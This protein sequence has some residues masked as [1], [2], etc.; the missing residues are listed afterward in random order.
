MKASNVMGIAC[1]MVFAPH[2]SACME[3]NALQSLTYEQHMAQFSRSLDEL[4]QEVTDLSK[5]HIGNRDSGRTE[6]ISARCPVNLEKIDQMRMHV[7]HVCASLKSD[8]LHTQNIAKTDVLQ[9]VRAIFNHL[10]TRLGDTRKL[11]ETYNTSHQRGKLLH[12]ALDPLVEIQEHLN[13]LFGI[14]DGYP[15]ASPH[16]TTI[17]QVLLTEARSFSLAKAFMVA[18]SFA[19]PSPTMGRQSPVSGAQSDELSEESIAMGVMNNNQR[20]STFS[21]SHNIR[22][23][24][25]KY[26]KL[27]RNRAQTA[28]KLAQKNPEH[29]SSV[30]ADL[31]HRLCGTEFVDETKENLGLIE[32]LCMDYPEDSQTLKE[33]KK[34]GDLTGK[35]LAKLLKATLP[36]AVVS[37]GDL[38]ECVEAVVTAAAKQSDHSAMGYVKHQAS[39]AA[40]NLAK[41]TGIVKE[42]QINSITKH[43]NEGNPF[44]KRVQKVTRIIDQYHLKGMLNTMIAALEGFDPFVTMMIGRAADFYIE[45]GQDYGKVLNIVRDLKGYNIT[46]TQEQNKVLLAYL[47]RLKIA[48]KH[49]GAMAAVARPS[50]PL[51]EGVFFE[52]DEDAASES[53]YETAPEDLDEEEPNLDFKTKSPDACKRI[54]VGVKAA[55]QEKQ[56]TMD[57]L[58]LCESEEIADYEK[59]FLNAIRDPDDEDDAEK[60]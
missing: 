49:P 11:L 36:N 22:Q 38:L 57:P 50:L 31:S 27:Y 60:E 59:D 47:G 12:S 51:S 5:Q 18:Q 19:D 43:V 20:A 2:Y 1:G 58:S 42:K 30:F 44:S 54:P 6:G 3:S 14:C 24:I 13:G 16:S 17:I 34:E 33:M 56:V 48:W 41:K 32:K 52:Q 10:D 40:V 21:W 4:A 15:Y 28:I 37:G 53:G 26:E 45:C 9:E 55:M 8:T 23:N 46:A 7:R 35:N 39:Q 25:D 29:I